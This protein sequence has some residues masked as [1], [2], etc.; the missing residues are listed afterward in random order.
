[1]LLH[2]YP[3]DNMYIM[4]MPQMHQ[5]TSKEYRRTFAAK[6]LAARHPSAQ[7]EFRIGFSTKNWSSDYVV[8]FIPAQ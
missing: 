2:S 8:T 7:A 4:I 1:M 3:P 5:K 6:S